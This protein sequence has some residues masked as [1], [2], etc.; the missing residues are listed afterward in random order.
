[1]AKK[2]DTLFGIMQISFVQQ[3]GLLVVHFICGQDLAR[4]IIHALKHQ[5]ANVPE[6]CLKVQFSTSRIFPTLS[7]MVGGLNMDELFD[8]NQAAPITT[9]STPGNDANLASIA[10]SMLTAI[11]SKNAAKHADSDKEETIDYNDMPMDA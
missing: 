4:G 1:M 3:N 10:T 8:K 2:V 11:S 5:H 6:K 7:G 9:T